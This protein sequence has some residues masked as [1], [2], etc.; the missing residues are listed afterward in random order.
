[1]K[2][3]RWGRRLALVGAS[4][5]ILGGAA[6]ASDPV[7]D[8]YTGKT[9][10]LLIGYSV[11]GGYDIYGRTV[12]RYLGK[13]I[14]G[15]PL[16]VPQNM[17]GAGS[18]RL[19]QYLDKAAA[20]DGTV[21]GT[22]ARGAA[23]EPLLDPSQKGAFDP[24]KLNWIGSVTNEVSTCAFWHTSPIKTWDDMKAKPFTVGGTGPS[25][26]TDVFP[27][28]IRYF[29]KLPLKLVTGFPGGADVVLSLERK[30]VDGRC[31]WSWSSLK[32]RH[33]SLYDEGKLSVTVQ[34]AL[35]KHEDLPNVPLIMDLTNDPKI[36]TALKLV[37]ARQSMARPFA[38]PPGTPPE[39]VA[40]IRKAFAETMKDPEFLAEAEKLELEVRPVDGPEIENLI[41]EMYATPTDVIQTVSE[42]IKSSDAA[43]R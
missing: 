15:N 25:A 42:A 11:G 38:M 22:F 26:D 9:V 33:K 5:L 10:Q 4:L 27:K 23:A 31:G 19:V 3:S 13:H 28:V 35:N 29:F 37:F 18:L 1:M 12:A 7:A 17:P 34:L 16:V 39:R 36:K 8:F 2:R 40:A 21:I 41:K 20:K 32:S 24:L 30:E 14:P 6:R 43:N